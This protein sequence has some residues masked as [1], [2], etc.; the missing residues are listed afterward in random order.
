MECRNEVF[1]QLLRCALHLVSCLSLLFSS[2]AAKARCL[3]SLQQLHSGSSQKKLATA[4][5]SNGSLP[6][7]A[8]DK[9][10]G[11]V[12]IVSGSSRQRVLI[13]FIDSC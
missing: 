3:Q 6:H 5:L 13:T 10:K 2:V 7:E 9:A 12:S 1:A 8:G 11:F 4:A